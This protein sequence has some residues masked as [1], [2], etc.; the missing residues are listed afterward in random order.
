[1]TNMSL[2]YFSLERDIYL[3]LFFYFGTKNDSSYLILV[4]TLAIGAR[5]FLSYINRLSVSL[6]I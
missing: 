2:T 4:I 3:S 6:G 1:M 5:V